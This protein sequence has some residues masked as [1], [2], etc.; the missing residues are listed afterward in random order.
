M[1]IIKTPVS[2]F[3]GNRGGVMFV[4][5]VGETS[6]PHLIE[7]FKSKGY[8]VE[9]TPKIVEKEQK[10][11]VVEVETKPETKYPAALEAMSFE[12][13]VD[14]AKSLGKKKGLGIL[15]T[16]EQVIKHIMK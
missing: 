8:T 13:L 3:N 12:E 11:E 14:Y 5:G 15:K 7:W 10:M 16:R 1:A 9:D 2:G 4:D 6:I